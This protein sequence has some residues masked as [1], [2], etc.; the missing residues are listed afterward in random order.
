MRIKYTF[1]CIFKSKNMLISHHCTTPNI[2]KIIENKY[3]IL[4][5]TS[6][7]NA[8][9]VAIIRSAKNTHEPWRLTLI[10]EKVLP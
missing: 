8:I 1:M 9:K 7:N 2:K 6:Q 4:N 3:I 5:A 10:N